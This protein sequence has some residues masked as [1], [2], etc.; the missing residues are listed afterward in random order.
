[1]LALQLF[2]WRQFQGLA[3]E[4]QRDIELVAVLFGQSVTGGV[5][6]CNSVGAVRGLFWSM[7]ECL[8][9]GG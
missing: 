8:R 3:E 7:R 5:P 6:G 9:G 1:M 2:L 4:A